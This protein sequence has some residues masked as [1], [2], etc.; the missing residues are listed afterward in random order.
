MIEAIEK[1]RSD[2]HYYGEFG[3]QFLSNSDIGTLLKNPRDF[4]K[5]QED[6]PAFA[7]GRYFHQLILEP[8][9]A[10]EWDFVDVASRNT[11]AYREH[12]E[13]HQVPFALLQKEANEMEDIVKVMLGHMDFFNDIR[14]DE[15]EYEVPCVKEIGGEMW[16]GKADVVH[17]DMV[18]DLKTTSNIADFRWSAKKYNYDSQAYIYSLMFGKP[19]VFYVVEKGTGTLGVFETSNAFIESGEA[20][21]FKAIEQYRT[22]FGDNPTEDI[23]S[24]FIHETL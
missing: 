24:Y 15:C 2:E 8:E 11:K 3:Q 10:T 17:P 16:K 4:K 13:S 19:L 12:C 14:D 18:I 1:L 6:N 21:V 20:K 5:K 22:F 9:K 7:K 23:N